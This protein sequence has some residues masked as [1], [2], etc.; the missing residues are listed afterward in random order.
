MDDMTAVGPDSLPAELLKLDHPEF[1]R[2]VPK[3]LVNV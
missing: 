3:L 1:V 2:E